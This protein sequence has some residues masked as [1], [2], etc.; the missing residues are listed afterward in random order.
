M[1]AVGSTYAP[2]RWLKLTNVA[3]YIVVIFINVASGQGWLGA[4][5]AEVSRVAQ[6]SVPSLCYV[7]VRGSP[8][9]CSGH[10]LVASEL[11]LLKTLD[12]TV[13]AA[14]AILLHACCT[15]QQSVPDTPHTQKV[16][17]SMDLLHLK[18]APDWVPCLQLGIFNMGPDLHTARFWGHLHTDSLGLCLWWLERKGDQHSRWVQFCASLL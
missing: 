11:P 7:L 16:R 1:Q 10:P 9:S 13:P 17:Q 6:A 2:G 15:G 14:P 5:N 8:H 3:A 4:S 18:K 12:A